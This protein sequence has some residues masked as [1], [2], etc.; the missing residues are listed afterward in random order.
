MQKQRNFFCTFWN[1]VINIKDNWTIPRW[2]ATSY[3][4]KIGYTIVWLKFVSLVCFRL[5]RL[6]N[7][8][9]ITISLRSMEFSL[10]HI[11]FGSISSPAGRCKFVARLSPLIWGGSQLTHTIWYEIKVKNCT[12]PPTPIQCLLKTSASFNA[13][14]AASLKISPVTDSGF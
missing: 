10:F 4:P 8:K 2:K 3:T 9:K 7:C 11:S 1:Q 6:K 14:V 13:A 12:F 5:I